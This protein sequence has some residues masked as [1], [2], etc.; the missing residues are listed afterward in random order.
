MLKNVR[1]RMP[2]DLTLWLKRKA[3]EEN[4]SVSELLCKLVERERLQGDSS[5]LALAE[6]KKRTPL[7][8]DAGE[9]MMREEFHERS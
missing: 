4:C 2:E 5:R 7:D 1:I 9:R 8:I 3:A 6:W